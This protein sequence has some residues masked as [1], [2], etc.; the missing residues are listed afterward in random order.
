MIVDALGDKQ[1]PEDAWPL[2]WLVNYA[3]KAGELGCFMSHVR[4]WKQMA[5]DNVQSALIMQSDADCDL[6]I[7]EVMQGVASAS[8][9]LLD[10][11]FYVPRRPGIFADD[12]EWDI[13][14]LS[15]CGSSNHKNHRISSFNDRAVSLEN[16]EYTFTHKPRN[17]QHRPGTR[18]VFPLSHTVY[19]TAFAISNA[20]AVKLEK[21]FGKGSDNI[22]LRLTSICYE[23]QIINFLGIWPQFVTTAI[24]DITSNIRLARS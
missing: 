3:K 14:W 8:N 17:K 9:R 24:T 16:D 11:P 21:K 10:R 4:T 15:H 7:L 18:S 6:R 13:I 5:A 1:I 12:D 22:D 20:G 2:G 23:N 19:S